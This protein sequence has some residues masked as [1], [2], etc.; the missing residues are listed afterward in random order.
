MPALTYFDGTRWNHQHSRSRTIPISGSRMLPAGNQS[1]VQHNATHV[2]KEA[3]SDLG[4]SKMSCTLLQLND[5]N[6]PL[7]SALQVP[8]DSNASC[9]IEENQLQVHE[10]C[11]ATKPKSAVCT[12]SAD[13]VLA[14]S[15]H[16]PNSQTT[17]HERISHKHKITAEQQAC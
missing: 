4:R 8:E 9:L 12:K 5:F 15:C 11:S 6:W 7:S 1:A 16:P 3:R 10:T 17:R 2:L 13:H 14:R